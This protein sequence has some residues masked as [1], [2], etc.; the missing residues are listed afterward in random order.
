VCGD[1]RNRTR[2]RYSV[3]SICLERYVQVERI[4]SLDLNCTII[5]IMRALVSHMQIFV[6]KDIGASLRTSNHIDLF[7]S[8]F[9]KCREQGLE[10]FSKLRTD[11]VIPFCSEVQMIF[12]P[13]I[14]SARGHKGHNEKKKIVRSMSGAYQVLLSLKERET[15]AGKDALRGL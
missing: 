10:C 11:G 9:C 7:D 2:I 12:M 5:A 3:F 6:Q 14:N 15:R 13:P 4:V 1:N 8:L